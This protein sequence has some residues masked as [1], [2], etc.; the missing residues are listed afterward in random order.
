MI[1]ADGERTIADNTARDESWL[2]KVENRLIAL[3]RAERERVY[4]HCREYTT[5]T[6]DW[7]A[8]L[9]GATSGH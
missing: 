1:H 5:N 3:D 8:C 9:D 2:T 6:F 4:R 7:L